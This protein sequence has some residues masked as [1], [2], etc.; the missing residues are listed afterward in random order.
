LHS[1]ECNGSLLIRKAFKRIGKFFGSDVIRFFCADKTL[2]WGGWRSADMG[3]LLLKNIM[4]LFF[5]K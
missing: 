3:G 2:F 5:E 1:G 4:E